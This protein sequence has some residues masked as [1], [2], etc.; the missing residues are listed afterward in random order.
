MLL[1][2]VTLGGA[3]SCLF[4][5]S[6]RCDADQ[7][8]NADAGSCV[9]DERQNKIAGDHG[10]VPCG[11]HATAKDDT[12]TCD[13]GYS[14]DG[15]TCIEK[16]EALGIDCKTNAD[17]DDATYDTCH[18]VTADSGYCTNTGCTSV[19][20]ASC[21][22]GYAC[23]LSATPAYCERPPSGAGMA[24]KTSADCQDTDAT[25]CESFATHQCFVQ[26]CSLTKNDCFP[27]QECCD[28]GVPSHGIVKALICVDAGTCKK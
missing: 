26:D 20:D 4:K 8:Y 28:L 22:S 1:A 15:M 16:P 19:D 18:L 17:C 27:G 6:D 25:Y 14:G 21:S 12:C 13:K 23:D 5:S 9:C 7:T 3:S 2:F 11:E 24:C 10:C